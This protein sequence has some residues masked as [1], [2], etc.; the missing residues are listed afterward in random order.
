MQKNPEQQ[1]Q[2]RIEATERQPDPSEQVSSFVEHADAI[3]ALMSDRIPADE[4]T[5]AEWR[6]IIELITTLPTH[7]REA[8]KTLTAAQ[9]QDIIRRYETVR[10]YSEDTRTALQGTIILL[11]VRHPAAMSDNEKDTLLRHLARY[12]RERRLYDQIM[13]GAKEI[14]VTLPPYLASSIDPETKETFAKTTADQLLTIQYDVLE[15]ANENL[16]KERQIS[17]RPQELGPHASTILDRAIRRDLTVSYIRPCLDNNGKPRKDD[18]PYKVFLQATGYKNDRIT[19]HDIH[20]AKMLVGFLS[21]YLPKATQL[22]KIRKVEVDQLPLHT[23]LDSLLHSSVLNNLVKSMAMQGD[24]M[25]RGTPPNLRGFVS[26]ALD[27]GDI[28]SGATNEIA[29]ANTVL[30]K[31]PTDENLILF[32]ENVNGAV[33]FMLND[34]KRMYIRDI[35]RDGESAETLM[36]KNNMEKRIIVAMVKRIQSQEFMNGIKSVTDLS[37]SNELLKARYG[38]WESKIEQHIESLVRDGDLKLNDAYQL[39]YLTEMTGQKSLPVA[40]KIVDLLENSGQSK[41]ADLLQHGVIRQLRSLMNIVDLKVKVGEIGLG[42]ETDNVVTLFDEKMKGFFS[43]IAED[44]LDWHLNYPAYAAALDIFAIP[45]VYRGLVALRLWKAKRFITMDP[46]EAVKKFHPDAMNDPVKLRQALKQLKEAQKELLVILNKHKELGVLH[47]DRGYR[48]R[49][50]A[51]AILHTRKAE[52]LAVIAKKIMKKYGSAEN[53]AEFLSKISPDELALRKALWSAG[54]KADE[55]ENSIRYLAVNDALEFDDVADEFLDSINDPTARMNRLSSDRSLPMSDRQRMAKELVGEG[56]DDAVQLSAA[57]EDVH[58]FKQTELKQAYEALD[59]AEAGVDKLAMREARKNVQKILIEKRDRL[60]QQ[61]NIPK[62]KANAL[63]RSGL[64][65]LDDAEQIAAL[66]ENVRAADGLT[67]TVSTVTRTI[68]VPRSL[69]ELKEAVHASASFD[70]AIHTLDDFS[71]S[72]TEL[73]IVQYQQVLNDSAID[74]LARTAGRA[75]ELADLREATSLAARSAKR[76]KLVR[77]GGI[78]AGT[79]LTAFGALVDGYL[80]YKTNERM[81][82][83]LNRGDTVEA[84]ILRSKFWSEGGEAAFGMGSGALGLAGALTGPPGWIALGGLVAKSIASETLYSYALDLNSTNIKEY[85]KKNPDELMALLRG[86][87]DWGVLDNNQGEQYRRQ[88]ALDAYIHSTNLAN[89]TKLDTLYIDTVLSSTPEWQ[90][91][92]TAS[93]REAKNQMKQVVL[94]E[95]NTNIA[96]DVSEFLKV[97]GGLDSPSAERLEVAIYY[98]NLKYIERRSTELQKPELLTNALRSLGVQATDTVRPQDLIRPQ[99]IHRQKA[100]LLMHQLAMLQTLVEE[101]K[102]SEM[103]AK[104][105]FM[106]I[107]K[108]QLLK[109]DV[110]IFL[111]RIHSKDNDFDRYLYEETLN[112]IL[113]YEFGRI[114][115]F[116]SFDKPEAFTKEILV[117]RNRVRQFLA[118]RTPFTLEQTQT[119]GS[120]YGSTVP[121]WYSSDA[122]QMRKDGYRK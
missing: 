2:A 60:M 42:Q 81:I 21:K 77:G 15:Q 1:P 71:A 105:Q 59:V 116:T 36:S 86:E 73:D 76:S 104:G 25:L 114:F 3:R 57:I 11:R 90:E 91:R 88:T 26:D 70:D 5:A 29:L 111:S 92:I 69:D 118:K 30:G 83:A 66:I 53:T 121:H 41:L 33:T 24:R 85:L 9:R 122:F 31:S 19:P 16:P 115:S 18:E 64:C 35:A 112:Q 46:M 97:N 93:P 22:A 82:D 51:L 78:I 12:V 8:P 65:G 101:G 23:V 13:A 117:L 61:W 55:V 79:G 7:P 89:L 63:V 47:L 39:L 87:G 54:F 74:D 72:I 75:D 44:F 109:H 68:E 34:G 58:T 14:E 6:Q 106:E 103:Q 110:N 43:N 94:Q 113:Y 99:E 40:F 62:P 52:D 48:L 32:R 37:E 119:G 120:H 96:R 49:G 102:I 50:R 108:E 38:D 28:Y 56:L 80:M 45:A 67:D 4:N 27:Q 95:K 10:D 107:I 98:A 20:A 100:E 17:D 84:E